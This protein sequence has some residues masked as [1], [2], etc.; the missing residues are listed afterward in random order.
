VG[1]HKTVT[2]LVRSRFFQFFDRFSRFRQF[3]RQ[4]VSILGS[5]KFKTGCQKTPW[6][7][8]YS[9]RESEKMTSQRVVTPKTCFFDRFSSF[10]QHLATFRHISSVSSDSGLPDRFWD[11]HLVIFRPRDR[12]FDTFAIFRPYFDIE[13][14]EGPSFAS[15]HR[16]VANIE[17]ILTVNAE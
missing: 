7:A 13:L 10:R 5:K 16:I 3:S 6:I 9:L 15:K 2:F 14:S 12:F 17:H 8:A 4:K 1:T 11:P